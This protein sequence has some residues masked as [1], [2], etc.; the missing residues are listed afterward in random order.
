M[1]SILSLIQIINTLKQKVIE[2]TKATKAAQIAAATKT[3]PEGM[4]AIAYAMHAAF[5]IIGED[6]P[7]A[8]TAAFIADEAL[9]RTAS[10][11][12]DN[13]TLTTA[14]QMI[15]SHGVENIFPCIQKIAENDYDLAS[16]ICRAMAKQLV[17]SLYYRYKGVQQQ[18]M[19]AARANGGG[20][21]GYEL[22]V[23]EIVEQ[24]A[25]YDGDLD[26]AKC[27]PA[28]QREIV[29]NLFS[30]FDAAFKA[31]SIAKMAW[32]PDYQ[33]EPLPYLTWVDDESKDFM[34]AFSL[35]EALAQLEKKDSDRILRKQENAKS[36]L[37]GLGSMTF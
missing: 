13:E 6:A 28:E 29:Q 20:V 12:R 4:T 30:Y 36:A 34:S 16:N 1:N 22:S 25:D 11:K 31:L 2:M 18:Q 7:V 10:M 8:N 35:D 32:K 21:D 15:S 19:L 33:P 26:D 3:I 9:T 14:L 23:S 17:N 5:A 24:Y 37:D 27:T